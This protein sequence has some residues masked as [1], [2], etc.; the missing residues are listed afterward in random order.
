MSKGKHDQVDMLHGPL[1]GKL[2]LFALPLALSSI[3]QQLFNAVDIAVLGQFATSQDQA[4]VGCTSAVINMFLNLFLGIS[5]GANVVIANA[6]GC[7]DDIMLYLIK[8]G[9]PEK[10]YTQ[11]M[12][13]T[14]ELVMDMG[15][16]LD[17]RRAVKE[18]LIDEL[19]GLSDALAWLY[20]EIEKE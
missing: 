19:G 20:K 15:T 8:C 10:R 4:A 6:I 17:G 1:L 14:G 18:K 2:V 12:L 3:L 5:V 13:H 7:R 11:L 16:V 9:M